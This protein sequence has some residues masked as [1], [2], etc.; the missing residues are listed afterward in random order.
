MRTA[1]QKSEGRTEDMESSSWLEFGLQVSIDFGHNVR[2]G[3]L[4]LLG[5]KDVN[6]VTSEWI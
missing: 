1:R 4:C 5:L 2:F 6:L 3:L